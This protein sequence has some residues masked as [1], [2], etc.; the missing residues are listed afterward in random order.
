[1]KIHKTIKIILII[2]FQILYLSLFCQ[3][4]WEVYLGHPNRSDYKDD[5]IETYDNGYLIVGGYNGHYGL[6]IKTSINGDMIYE[7]AYQYNNDMRVLAAIQ[8]SM[9]NTYQCGL[10]VVY[11]TI[12]W[13]YL[14][15]FDSCGNKV[16]CNIYNGSPEYTDGWADDIVF[17]NNNEIIVLTHLNSLEHNKQIFLFAYDTDG[18]NLW[19]KA[20]A[21]HDDHPLIAAAGAYHLL[22]DNKEFYLSGFCYWPFPGGDT[23]H[24]FLRPFFIGIDSSYNEKWI[25]PFAVEDSVFG[26]AFSLASINGSLMVGVGDRWVEGTKN[27]LIMFFNKEGETLGYYQL[28]NSDIGEDILYNGTLDVAIIND[29][30]FICPSIWGHSNGDRNQGELILGLNGDI[31]HL[32]ERGTVYGNPIIIKT[33]RSNYLIAN[34]VIVNSNNEDIILYK[35]NENLQQVPFDT[36]QYTYDSLCPYPITSETID[37]SDCM[38]WT[39]TEEIPTPEEYYSKLKTIP[40]KAFP[41]PA[42]DKITFAFENTDKHHKISLDCYDIYGRQMHEQKIYPGQLEAELDISNWGKGLYFVVVKS[43]G[44]IVGKGKFVVE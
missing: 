8:D 10:L 23:I 5:I 22:K 33:S 31:L 14:V 43:N 19:K 40:V 24:V 44:K 42:S 16:W 17:G 32:A 4:R 9:G 27:S 18:N 3:N 38:I 6:G 36:N 2:S 30:V 20:Y 39:D 29:S 26:H 28:L 41:N 34:E 13:P 1:M 12:S 15:K 25:L 11:G 21:I 7:K 37:L 35:V